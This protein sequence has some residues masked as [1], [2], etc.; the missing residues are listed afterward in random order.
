MGDAFDQTGSDDHRLTTI[1]NELMKHPESVRGKN[2]ERLIC[3]VDEAT[4]LFRPYPDEGIAADIGATNGSSFM[5]AM[6]SF[7]KLSRHANRL[8]GATSAKPG[9]WTD[10]IDGL[11]Y[12]IARS[13]AV[14][15][16]VSVE[17]V[18]AAIEVIANFPF[19]RRS[20]GRPHHDEALTQAVRAVCLYRQEEGL[21]VQYHFSAVEPLG[22]KG[23]KSTN[24]QL[25]PTTDTSA[26]AC[27]VARLWDLGYNVEVRTELRNYH[28][29][30]K[31]QGRTPIID[32]LALIFSTTAA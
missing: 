17:A 18:V 13:K 21:P 19:P 25:E 11:R 31:A 6:S 30:L 5:T 8:L 26:L 16:D 3:L 29:F 9:D 22:D 12:V 32:D 23:G 28:S 1:R 7:A 20:R 10:H 4:L 24:E 27:D 2:I 15:A 14:E